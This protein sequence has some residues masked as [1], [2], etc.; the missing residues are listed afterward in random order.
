MAL[1]AI[2]DVQGCN[3]ELGELLRVI[4]FNADRDQAWF[5]GDLVNR[6]PDS[7]GVLRR[8]RALG[9]SAVV[10]LGNHDL[11]LVARAFGAAQPKKSDT[12]DEVLAAQDRDS[13]I[14]WLVA[15][16]FLH[17]DKAQG[18]AMIHA[19]LPPQWTQA[20][21]RKCADDAQAALQRN[22]TGF[23]AT[24]YGD[25]PS[26]W[27]ADL[28]GPERLR[29]ITNCFTRM[30]YVRADGALDLKQKDAPASSENVKL[31]PW[32]EC[33]S[34][35]W[36]GTRVIFG[37]WSTLGFFR[38]RHVTCLDTG[39]AWGNTLTALRLDQPEAEPIS[40]NCERKAPALPSK[41]RR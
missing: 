32:F 15:R 20:L 25:Q 16:P 2:G 38:D 7:L 29:F 35:R 21:A 28:R 33:D 40:V 1:Y 23:V 11:H 19:G 41:S 13:L 8:V 18:L 9:D 31:Q 10:V 14:Q 22:P 26:I 17:E 36:R 39:C 6:G 34:A 4:G 24:M 30:R 37:H 3:S 12:L 27:D 5:V